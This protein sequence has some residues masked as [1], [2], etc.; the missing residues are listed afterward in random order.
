MA[1]EKNEPIEPKMFPIST[2]RVSSTLGET[3]LI[4]AVTSSFSLR[5]NVITCDALKEY[6]LLA[7]RVRPIA[8]LIAK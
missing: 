2:M 8:V 3:T 5:K 4:P 7:I 6:E 1:L